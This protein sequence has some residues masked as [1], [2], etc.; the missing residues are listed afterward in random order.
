MRFERPAVRPRC[1]LPPTTSVLLEVVLPLEGLAA[2]LAGE[3]DVVLVGALVDHEVVGLGEA[4]LAVL[5]D[6]L[7]F[8]PHPLPELPP[9][10]GLDLHYREHG[11]FYSLFHY[12]PLPALKVVSHGLCFSALLVHYPPSLELLL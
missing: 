6:K 5:A 10:F 3:G 8:G 7:A 2:D 9:L 4:S 12:L 11:H 1:K